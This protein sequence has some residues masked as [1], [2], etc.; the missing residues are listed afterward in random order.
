MILRSEFAHIRVELDQNGNGPRLLV[1]D[2]KALREIYLDPLELACLAWC[3]HKDLAALIDP[4]LHDNDA[5]E[6]EFDAVLRDLQS[7]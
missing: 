3:R 5:D 6:D 4:S 7:K 2:E 1:R